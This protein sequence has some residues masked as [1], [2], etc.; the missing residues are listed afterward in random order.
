MPRN[1]ALLQLTGELE[2]H[3]MAQ[4][5]A[6]IGLRA[7]HNIADGDLWGRLAVGAEVWLRGALP[8]AGAV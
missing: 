4:V 8:H 6:Y 3:R 1:E 7:A 2:R 5:D